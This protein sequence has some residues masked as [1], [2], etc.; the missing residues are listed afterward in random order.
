MSTGDNG[1]KDSVQAKQ[2]PGELYVISF[3][4]IVFVLFFYQA[5]GDDGILQGE[6][7][8]PGSISQLIIIAAL[9]MLVAL[10][11]QFIKSHYKEE[12]ISKVIETLFS[13]D[14]IV[15][16]ISILLYAFL[17]EKIGFILTSILFLFV[18]MAML[19]PKKL[20]NK[21]LISLGTVGIIVVIFRYVF[22]VL[23]P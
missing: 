13:K 12:S 14:L 4:F 21:L 16:I 6:L 19:E 2:K 1:K 11:I 20:L 7:N 15:T 3:I 10:F 22:Q 17:L 23:L 5:F 9:V 8:G 18:T